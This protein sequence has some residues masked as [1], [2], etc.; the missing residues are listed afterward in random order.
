M[1]RSLH[2]ARGFTL[3]ELMIVVAVVAILAAI[4]YPSYTEHVARS[5]RAEAKSV[6]LENAQ[7]IERQYTRSNAY[8]KMPDRSTNLTTDS[9]PVKTVPREGG[10]AQYNISF[11]DGQ[12]TAN[13]FTLQA[14]PA[15]PMA[16]DKCGSLTLTHTG[17]KNA[18]G[19]GATVAQ[20]WDR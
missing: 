3:I 5:R 2:G 17:L 11:V 13:S 4:A 7:W 16:N 8:N 20:C 9:L 6:L 18:T 19:T 1:K 10:T 12:P 15:G 14:V